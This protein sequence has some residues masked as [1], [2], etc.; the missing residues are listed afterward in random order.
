MLNNRINEILERIQEIKRNI[1]E[2]KVETHLIE[3]KEVFQL[4]QENKEKVKTLIEE[5]NFLY[6]EFLILNKQEEEPFL[7]KYYKPYKVILDNDPTRIITLNSWHGWRYN[8]FKTKKILKIFDD[9]KKIEE[10]KDSDL[11]KELKEEVIKNKEIIEKLYLTKGTSAYYVFYRKLNEDK[12]SKMNIDNGVIVFDTCQIIESQRVIKN[13]N[14]IPY[15][16]ID[17]SPFYIQ[18]KDKDN[19]AL[20]SYDMLRFVRLIEDEFEIFISHIM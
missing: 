6:S 15:T 3:N 7:L 5:W 20:L 17:D 10:Y 16:Q 1:H 18:S 8:N 13:K 12:I 4:S 11:L 19:E 2:L 14:K 9:L